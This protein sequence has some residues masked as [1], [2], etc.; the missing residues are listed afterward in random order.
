MALLGS[1]DF[2]HG[3]IA[4]AGNYSGKTRDQIFEL[5][6]NSANNN[7]FIIGTTE[8]GT[9]VIG[10]GYVTTPKRMFT[11]VL[12]KDKTK[13]SDP[14]TKKITVPYTKVFKSPDFGGGARGAGGG[15]AETKITE[16]L[17]CYYNSYIYNTSNGVRRGKKLLK[18]PPTK[19]EL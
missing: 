19:D 6:I 2:A 10:V 13:I 12:P 17:Q 5:K 14:K 1:S 9:K 8:S 18:K 16:S 11:Y 4:S 7:T 15:T 3:K